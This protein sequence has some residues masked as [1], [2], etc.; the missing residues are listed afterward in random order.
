MAGSK[1]KATR[2]AEQTFEETRYLKHLIERRIPVC[3][4]LADN[5]VVTG[6]VEYYDQR[7]IRI[8]RKDAPNLFIFKHDI[9][10]LYEVA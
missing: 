9:K 1:G 6:T 2:P 7:F 5:D 8:T 4:K 10:Y 3:V